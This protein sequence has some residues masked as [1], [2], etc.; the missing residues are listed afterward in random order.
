MSSNGVHSALVGDELLVVLNGGFCGSAAPEL[1]RL[2]DATLSQRRVRVVIDLA[3][4]TLID[5]AG[6]AVI[7]ATAHRMAAL[8]SPLTLMLPGGARR[9]VADAAA[10]RSLFE[11]A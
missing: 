3:R 4:V 7:A 11:A 1:Q 8:A 5:D 9:E 6:C 10:V 2:L